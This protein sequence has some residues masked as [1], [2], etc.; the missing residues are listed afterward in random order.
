MRVEMSVQRSTRLS[1]IIAAFNA[2]ETVARCL[3]SLRAQTFR[4]FEVIL[5]DSSPGDETARIASGFPEIR[6]E[7]SASRLYPHEARNRAA[8]FAR[9]ELL[10]SVDAD[11]YPHPDWLLQ[12]VSEYDASGQVIVGA[13]ACHGRRLRD[14]G[15]HFCKFAK[16]LPA[17]GVRVIDTAPTANLLVARADFERVGGMHGDQYLADVSLGRALEAIGKQLRFAPRAVVDHHHTESIAAFLRE[18]YVRGRL[19][20][21]MRASWLTTRRSIALY[22]VVSILP[23]RFARIAALTFRYCAAAGMTGSFLLTWP[24]ALAG[25]AA[26]LAGESV[27]YAGALV[28]VRARRPSTRNSGAALARTTRWGP[29]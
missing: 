14:L 1:V 7:H 5:V 8:S 11:V 26:S 9:G 22:L 2:H 23:I 17:G 27:A 13:I 15:M 21:R 6:F 29:Q 10:V 16:F 25:H 28:R 19:F 18:R 3:A 24:L 12:L 4:D 20:G